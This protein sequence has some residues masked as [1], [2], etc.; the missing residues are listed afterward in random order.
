MDITVIIPA[1]KEPF[2]EK[3]WTITQPENPIEAAAAFATRL[4]GTY[5]P[6]SSIPGDYFNDTNIQ[7]PKLEKA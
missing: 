3:N 1:R 5:F 2:I 4:S 6:V 7:A